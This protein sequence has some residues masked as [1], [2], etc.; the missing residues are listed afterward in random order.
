[1]SADADC[2]WTVFE[3]GVAAATEAILRSVPADVGGSAQMQRKMMDVPLNGSAWEGFEGT[4]KS[5]LK[6]ILER[7]EAS[8]LRA[9][10]S[11]PLV[12][13]PAAVRVRVRAQ[14]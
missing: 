11:P 8:G 14:A 13:I 2:K 4:N 1:M 3:A 5:S 9:G 6:E 10:T 12:R 7:T